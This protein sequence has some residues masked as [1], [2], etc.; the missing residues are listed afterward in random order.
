MTHAEAPARGRPLLHPAPVAVGAALLIASFGTA[1]LYWKT[2]LFQ[3]NNFSAWLLLGGLLMAAVAAVAFVVDL[4]SRRLRRIAWLR[5]AGL[6]AAALLSLLN[7]L[8]H[9]RD[10]YTAVVPEGIALS[11]VVT[12]LL[13]AVG[14]G[15]WSLGSSRHPAP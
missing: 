10:A 12:V 7:I 9:S 1:A 11:A 4:A 14:V 2:L 5:L 3:W 8:V 6:T 15:G 13:I